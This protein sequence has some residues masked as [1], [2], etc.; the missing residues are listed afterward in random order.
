MP[1]SAL[2]A[3]DVRSACI[4]IEWTSVGRGTKR[5]SEP[6]PFMGETEGLSQV[7]QRNACAFA[8]GLMGT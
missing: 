1:D 3:H 5:E 6:T 2:P 7:H 8:F 4:I